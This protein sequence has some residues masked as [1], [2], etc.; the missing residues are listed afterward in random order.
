MIMQLCNN[1]IDAKIFLDVYDWERMGND[2]LI[3]SGETTL[4]QLQ[5]NR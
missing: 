2:E 1:D 4:R 3:V 5:T